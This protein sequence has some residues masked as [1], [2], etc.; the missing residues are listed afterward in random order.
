[1]KKLLFF[2]PLW[3]LLSCCNSPE[4]CTT[5]DV[6]IYPNRVLNLTIN[7]SDICVLPIETPQ[8]IF[9]GDIKQMQLSD[10]GFA[11][12]DGTLKIFSK[13]NQF[14]C[15]ASRRGKAPGEFNT[16]DKVRCCDSSIYLL[17]CVGSCIRRYSWNGDFLTRYDL[18]SHPVDFELIDDST[19]VLFNGFLASETGC[20]NISFYNLNTRSVTGVGLEFPSNLADVVV[21]RDRSNFFKSNG[22]V[23][24]S[25]S[26][27]NKI[28]RIC[29]NPYSVETCFAYNYGE[30]TLTDK[31]LDCHYSDVGDFIE[32]LNPQNIYFNNSGSIAFGD[33]FV[34]LLGFPTNKLVAYNVTGLKADIFSRFTINSGGEIDFN[35]RQFPFATS[36]NYLVFALNP[37]TLVDS[38][39]LAC[40]L[41]T[42]LVDSL[43]IN[44]TNISPSS[45]PFL[46]YLNK[47]VFRKSMQ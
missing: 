46:V 22:E 34:T 6:A 10:S 3:L 39:S 13:D 25:H 19:I 18:D 1:M 8:G 15:T 40:G 4:P 16:A 35:Y 12:I 38:N 30:H 47:E 44:L 14:V 9:V 33:E 23:Y 32:R 11:L 43:N 36:G 27:S 28:F 7:K 42:L 21:F 2:V 26:G 41:R 24:L 17:D 31:L 37:S 45:N 29:S 20:Y 5:V